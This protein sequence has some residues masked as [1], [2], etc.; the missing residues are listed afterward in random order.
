MIFDDVT[1]IVGILKDQ[2]PQPIPKDQGDGYY[3]VAEATSSTF[4]E[5]HTSQHDSQLSHIA[6]MIQK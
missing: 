6:D 5:I 2:F 1:Y 4:I 3:S